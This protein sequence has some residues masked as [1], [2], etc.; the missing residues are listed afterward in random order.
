MNTT[1]QAYRAIVDNNDYG[2]GSV[3]SGSSVAGNN[4]C[5]LAFDGPSGN[6]VV[7]P[8]QQYGWSHNSMTATST[9]AMPTIATPTPV[10]EAAR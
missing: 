6:D 10:H 9:I 5:G 3:D 1:I 4:G 7:Q 8:S 2:R